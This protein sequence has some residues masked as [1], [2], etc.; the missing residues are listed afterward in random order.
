M[1][2][3]IEQ[4]NNNN[5]FK[6]EEKLAYLLKPVNPN[7]IFIDKLQNRL[8]RSPFIFLESSKKNVG[9]LIMGAGLFAGALTLW[10]ISHI[11]KPRN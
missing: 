3:N 9:L 1:Q 6:L 10:V 5:I 11:K 8:S 2:S 4:T 7:P